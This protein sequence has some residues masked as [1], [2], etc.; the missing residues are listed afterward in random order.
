MKKNYV[1]YNAG[2]DI[3]RTGSC[4]DYMF[5]SLPLQGEFI[6]EGVGSDLTDYVD[7][8]TIPPTIKEK[9]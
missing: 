4:P 6:L 9:E 2:G 3:I 7:T 8:S 1:I 5:D